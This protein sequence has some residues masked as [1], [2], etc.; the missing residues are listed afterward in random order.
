MGGRKNECVNNTNLIV[1]DYYLENQKPSFAEW[2]GKKPKNKN[3]KKKV[4]TIKPHGNISF[5]IEFNDR[6]KRFIIIDDNGK[7]LCD[8]QGYGYKTQESARKAGW[9][10]F[11]GGKDKIK[12]EEK[13]WRRNKEFAKTVNSLYW[14]NLKMIGIGE[15]TEDDI[16]ETAKEIAEESGIVDFDRRRMKYL[17]DNI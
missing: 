2:A 4:T 14:D 8:A 11:S 13:W 16:F 15:I 6:L 17:P 1:M 3:K 9:F 10:K 5:K 12:Q 7:L